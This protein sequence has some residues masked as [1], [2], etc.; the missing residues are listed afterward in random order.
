[1]DRAIFTV[2]HV[3]TPFFKINRINSEEINEGAETWTLVTTLT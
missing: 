3:N 1:M 2:R